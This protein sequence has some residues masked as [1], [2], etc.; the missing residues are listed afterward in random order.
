MGRGSIGVALV[1]VTGFAGSGLPL[2]APAVRIA[3]LSLQA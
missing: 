1:A 2:L 3:R